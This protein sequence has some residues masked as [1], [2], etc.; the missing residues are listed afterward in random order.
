MENEKILLLTADLG[1]MALEVFSDPLPRQF[2]NVGVS[3][4]NMVGMAAGL[5]QSGYIPFCYSITPFATLRPYEF[6]RNTANQSLAVRIV[7]MGGGFEYG[8]A[9]STHHGLED[10][11]VMRTNPQI[12]IIAP[13]DSAQCRSALLQE[14][15][16]LK[17]TYW[18]LG[19]DG[20]DIPELGGI[21]TLGQSQ[22]LRDGSDGLLVSLGP[23]AR[24]SQEA[25]QILEQEQG[26]KVGHL[27]VSSFNHDVCRHDEALLAALDAVPLVL[28]VEEHYQNGGLGS[29][30]AELIAE[31]G[32]ATKLV[33]CGVGAKQSRNGSQAYHRKAHG[34]LASQLAHSFL[35][36]R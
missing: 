33:R 13:A 27:V 21:F 28:S 20:P 12:T 18:R 9:G 16:R 25:T 14:W 7:G 2:Y 6:I 26:I 36:N 24:E 8:T 17:T 3:E 29:F 23:I 34:L 19:K 35:S 22:R 10:L 4:Q 32:L 30:L 31:A 5:A 15:E 11:A 1:F